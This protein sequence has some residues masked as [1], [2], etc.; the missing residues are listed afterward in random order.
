MAGVKRLNLGLHAQM[1]HH[2]AHGL[3]HARRVGHHVIGLG[4]IHRAAVQRADLGQALFDMFHPF[5]RADHIS[6]VFAERQRRLS[7]AKDHVATHARRQ[8]Q[9][10]VNLGFADAV[11]HLAIII[12]PPGRA[13]SVRVT[14]V[15]MHDRRTRLGGVDGAVGDLFGRSR[16]MRAAVLGTT[17]SSDSAGDENLSVHGER[18]GRL[19]LVWV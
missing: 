12:Q 6:A 15:A 2:P 14:H 10:H 4:K 16:H 8:V 1:G 13:A 3:Q 7:G 17:G 5:R 9:D 18:H 11:G 19:P